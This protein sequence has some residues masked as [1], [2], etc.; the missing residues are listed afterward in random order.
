MSTKL[1]MP[2]VMKLAR[3]LMAL[4]PDSELEEGQGKR[5]KEVFSV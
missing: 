3:E 4:K 2:E 1:K 5:F